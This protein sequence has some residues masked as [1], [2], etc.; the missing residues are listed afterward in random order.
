MSFFT[1]ISRRFIQMTRVIGPMSKEKKK[2]KGPFAF[3]RHPKPVINDHDLHYQLQKIKELKQS[4]IADPSPFH[5][6]W[7]YK[8]FSYLP[9]YEKIILRR[10]GLNSKSW[11][12]P[13]VVPN[14]PHFNKLL[15]QVKHLIRLKPI[16]FPNGIP[17]EKDIGAT[18]LCQYTGVLQVNEALRVDDKRLYGDKLPALYEGKYLVDYLRKLSGLFQISH[19]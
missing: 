16:T 12:D 18:K 4:V 7:R 17:T 11:C 5:V 13:V 15:W 10:L 9:W 3:K 2:Y 19:G 6:V 14:T 8:P 1:H